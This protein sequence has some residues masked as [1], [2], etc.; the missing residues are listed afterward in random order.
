LARQRDLTA[1]EALL[2]REGRAAAELDLV[3]LLRADP[4]RQLAIT[5]TALIGSVETVVGFGAIELDRPGVG[6]QLLVVDRAAT[7]GLQELLSEALLGR[8]EALQRARAA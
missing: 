3:R 6:P 8:A 1:L 2:Q 4:R 7:D 5:A